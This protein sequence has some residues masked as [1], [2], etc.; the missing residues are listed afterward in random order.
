MK[1]LSIFFVIFFSLILSSCSSETHYHKGNM[2]THTLWS[3]GDDFP[4]NVVKWYKDNGYNFLVLTDHNAIQDGEKLRRLPVDH[5]AILKSDVT[6]KKKSDLNDEG[7]V[8]VRL[9]EIEKFRSKFEDSGKFL[10]I[11]GNEITCPASVHLT[12]FHQEYSLSAPLG[13]ASERSR[14]IKDAVKLVDDYRIKSGRNTYPV[15]AHPNF[16]WAITAEMII[17]NPELRFFEVYNGHPQVNNNG[18]NYRASTE[19]IWDIVLAHRLK[20]KDNNLIYGLAVDDAHG[21]HE[22]DGYRDRGP[23][24]GWVMV[25]SK[26]LTPESILDALDNGGF[27]SSTGV[28]INNIKVEGGNIKIKINSEKGVSYLT[29]FIGTSKNFDILS[30][31]ALDSIGNEIINTTRIY[32]NQIGEIL[33]TSS[34]TTPTYTFSGDELYV[35]VCITS[36][37]NQVDLTG[38]VLGKQKAW[39][40]PIIPSKLNIQVH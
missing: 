6:I 1:Q 33:S 37:A 15:L 38:K 16:N 2:H 25:K 14:M 9:G 23:G 21:Y 7:F 29:E 12:S 32:T 20:E 3:D 30:H 39:L 8:E 36:S 24:R 35:R 22:S 19:R 28:E 13:T 5:P 27:Y 17:E 34:S 4:E 31:P 11:R 10:L 18:D 40:Q 26:D